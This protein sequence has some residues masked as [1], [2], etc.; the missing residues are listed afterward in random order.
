[1]SNSAEPP[2]STDDPRTLGQHREPYDAAKAVD[3]AW[4]SD[5]P[6]KP[7]GPVVF[8]TAA[9]GMGKTSTCKELMARGYFYYEGDAYF[10]GAEQYPAGQSPKSD[11]R[12]GTRLFTDIPEERVNAGNALLKAII[13]F[14][15]GGPNPTPEECAPFLEGLCSDVTS[16]HQ[17]LGGSF[18]VAFAV[19]DAASR[20]LVRDFMAENGKTAYIVVLNGSPELNIAR[21]KRRN[22]EDPAEKIPEPISHRCRGFE[23]ALPE[24]P[25][26]IGI[27]VQED[28][29]PA[30]I[31]DIIQERLKEM[32]AT[33]Q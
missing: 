23:A 28:Q 25:N 20:K 10:G 15:Q 27:E 19:Y 30:D 3:K 21:L 9:S 5:V 17:R 1:M 16:E 8:V 11:T 32:G 12:S 22:I 26:T 29:T 7:Q 24:E 6:P 31:A 13:S 33:G 4:R 18:V 2:K 14:V